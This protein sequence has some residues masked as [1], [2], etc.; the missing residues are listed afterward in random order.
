MRYIDETHRKERSYPT[1]GRQFPAYKWYKPILVGIV[2]LVFYLILTVGLIIGMGVFKGV[3]TGNSDMSELFAQLELGYDGMDMSDPMQCLY[4]L[5]GIAI[6]IPALWLASLI[7]RD[8]PFSSYSSSRGGWS[9]KVFWRVFPVAFLC[10]T[11]PI[12]F[13]ELVVHHHYSDFSVRFTLGGFIVLTIL[14][15]LQCIAEEYIFRGFLMQTLGSWVRVPIIAVIIQSLIFAAGHPY[16]RIGQIGIFITGMVFAVSAW[17]GRGL[18]VPAAMH[19]CNNMTIFY[20]QGL[21]M[22]TISSQS[23][24]EE[25]IFDVVTG[26]IYLIF[27]FALSKKTKWFD[28]VRKNDLAK[29]REKYA[30]KAAKKAAKLNFE[31]VNDNEAEAEAEAAAPAPAAD[32]TAEVS[33]ETADMGKSGKY[34]GRH[35]KN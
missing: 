25:I 34:E 16:N 6:M 3:S 12:L 17:L 1:Y 5:G 2:F 27:I 10:I 28:R 33:Q 29:A 26:A 4:S 9:S 8:R 15:P 30:R 23:D 24:M 11:I 21:N 31:V 7:V 14:G 18:E 35:Y 19:I 13:M 32:E 22:T 20:L